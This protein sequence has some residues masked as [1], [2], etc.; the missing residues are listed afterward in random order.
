MI[1]LLN[2][3][4]ELLVSR[5]SLVRSHYWNT[6]GDPH[7][8]LCDPKLLVEE[9]KLFIGNPIIVIEDDPL[10]HAYHQRPKYPHC[11]T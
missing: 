8:R 5:V 10:G 2:R 7:Y 1:L 4:T 11:R 6:I 9:P 3:F